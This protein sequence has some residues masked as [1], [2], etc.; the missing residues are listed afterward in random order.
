MKEN[1]SL[2]LDSELIEFLKREAKDDFR[3]VNNYIEMILLKHMQEKQATEN[4][5]E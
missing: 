2:R 3:N 1:I 5:G 4:P